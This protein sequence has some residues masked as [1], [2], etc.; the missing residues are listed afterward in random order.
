MYRGVVGGNS[1][2]LP[3]WVGNGPGFVGGDSLILPRWVGNKPGLV[4]GNSLQPNGR[5]LGREFWPGLSQI[6]LES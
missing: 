5:H 1:I 6:L 2:Y 3:R 4:G